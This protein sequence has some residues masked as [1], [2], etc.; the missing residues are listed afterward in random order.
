MQNPLV[1]TNL[2]EKNR[3]EKSLEDV[4]SEACRVLSLI[5]D[6]ST[7][8]AAS[9]DVDMRMESWW[10]LGNLAGDAK[11]GLDAAA[12]AL[13]GRIVVTRLDDLAGLTVVAKPVTTPAA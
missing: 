8:F 2:V 4:L 11:R 10:L 3:V 9:S 13:P 7:A 12:A 1:E 5:D 6:L